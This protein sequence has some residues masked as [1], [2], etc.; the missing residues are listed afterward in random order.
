MEAGV[1]V[2]SEAKAGIELYMMLFWL[3]QFRIHLTKFQRVQIHQQ[4]SR[5]HSS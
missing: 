4:H 5:K 2:A 1:E 3:V